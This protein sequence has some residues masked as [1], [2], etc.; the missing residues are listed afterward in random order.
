[1]RPHSSPRGHGLPVKKGES[2]RTLRAAL[3]VSTRASAHGQTRAFLEQGS[4]K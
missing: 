1:M 2:Y 4:R 3:S